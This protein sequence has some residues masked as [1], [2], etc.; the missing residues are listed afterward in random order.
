MDSSTTPSQPRP[1]WSRLPQSWP[2]PQ[3][4]RPPHLSRPPQSWPPLPSSPSSTLS[5]QQGSSS[6]PQPSRP[7]TR[8]SSNTDT[9]SSI[10]RSEEN[11]TLSINRST[12]MPF[13]HNDRIK[14]TTP[15]G[16]S[17]ALYF[18]QDPKISTNK[19]TNKQDVSAFNNQRDGV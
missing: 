10:E 16:G 3:S 1:H 14:N 17:S 13:Y 2:R 11:A 12:D 7:S 6:T 15:E 5:H 9:R 19:Q 18:P 8:R 4:S